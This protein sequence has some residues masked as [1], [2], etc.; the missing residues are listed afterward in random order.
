MLPTS[1]YAGNKWFYFI[2]HFYFP[3]EIGLFSEND[4]VM[5]RK[6]H[7]ATSDLLVIGEAEIVQGSYILYF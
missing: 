5:S 1:Y 3:T 6:E 7:F 2:I 4:P